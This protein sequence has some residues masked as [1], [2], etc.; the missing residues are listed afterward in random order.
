MTSCTLTAALRLLQTCPQLPKR[1]VGPAQPTLRETHA[2]GPE[3]NH[4]EPGPSFP[5]PRGTARGSHEGCRLW[6]Q[7]LGLRP[8]LPLMSF[9]ARDMPAPLGAALFSDF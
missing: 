6:D 5:A 8:A 2:G 3:S 9:V 4:L 7:H 1:T